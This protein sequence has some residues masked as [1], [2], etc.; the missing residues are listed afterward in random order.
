MHQTYLITFPGPVGAHAP[1]PQATVTATGELSPLGNPVY[2]DPAGT[3]RVEITPGGHACP[4]TPGPDGPLH[5][6]PLD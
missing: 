2:S 1:Q 3:L 6:Q 4:L 5:A